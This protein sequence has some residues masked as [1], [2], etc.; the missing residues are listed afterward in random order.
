MSV[1]KMHPLAVVVLGIVIGCGGLGSGTSFATTAWKR[2]HASACYASTSS[3]YVDYVETAGIFNS[4]F[5]SMNY[6]CPF[7]DDSTIPR[8]S[9]T[10]L[11]LHG[12]NGGGTTSATACMKFWNATGGLTFGYNCGATKSVYVPG[13][14]TLNFT[15]SSGLTQW[16]SGTVNEFGY[17]KVTLGPSS[18]LFGFYADF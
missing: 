8:V 14:Y 18:S 2:L 9:M 17:V 11:N 4:G 3:D 16:G 15:P 6:V 12:Y 10:T 13:V 7:N 1:A 5:S